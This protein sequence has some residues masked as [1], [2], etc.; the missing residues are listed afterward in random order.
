M[1]IDC[2]NSERGSRERPSSVER[3]TDSPYGNQNS[4]RNDLPSQPPNSEGK[5]WNYPGL[6]LMTSGAFWQNYSG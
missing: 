1:F 2:N 5:A 6:D 3:R 4:G